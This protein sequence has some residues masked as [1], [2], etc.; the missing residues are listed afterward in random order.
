MEIVK[1]SNNKVVAMGVVYHQ[2][3]MYKFSHFLPYYR[4]KALLSHAN[5]SNNLWHDRFSHM[6]YKYLQS[7]N[8][9]GMVEGL[10]PIKTSNGACIGCVVGKHPV[11][12][13]VHL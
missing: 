5:E 3:R 4:G 8:K 11:C 12:T 6:N 7:L 1:I 2:D 10:P 13:S 9:E